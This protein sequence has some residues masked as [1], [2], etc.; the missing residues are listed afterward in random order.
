MK[1]LLLVSLC[2]LMLCVTQGFAQ[3]RVITGT[4]TSKD[5]GLPLPGVSVTVPGTAIGTQTNATGAYSLRVSGS[6][7]VTL[8]FAFIGFASQTISAPE[9]NVLNVALA[10]DAKQLG[11][12][13]INAA[14][15]IQRKTRE[16]GYQNTRVTSDQLTQGKAP[17]VA[18]GLTGKVAGLQIN[19]VSSGVNPTYRLVLRGNRSLTGNN[20]ALLVLDNVITPSSVLGNLNPE[21]IDDITVLN[22]ASAAALYGSDASNGALVVTTKKGK[23]GV[24]EIKASHLSTVEQV[25]FYPK[26]QSEFG[27]G[28]SS[29][30]QVYD[31]IENQQ[32]GP[33]F[34]GTLRQ[35][36]LP[37]QDGSVQT[38]PYTANRD[39]Y[40]FW[41]SGLT[42]QEDFS[43]SS[44]DEKS[45]LFLSGQ[46]LNT[47][48]TTNNDNYKRASVR[49]NGT[50]DFGNKLKA[51]YAVSFVQNTSDLTTATSTVY[52][53]LL[54]TPAQIPLLSYKDYVNNP[55]ANPNG[56]YNGY[57]ANPYFTIDNNRNLNRNNYLTGNV[58]LNYD[59]LDWLGFTGRAGLSSR[60]Q[61]NK[62]HTG[63]FLFT[64][65]ALET[66]TSKSNIAGSESDGSLS[67]V[68]INAEFQTRLRK[69]FGDFL[70][71]FIA[72]GSLRQ[73]SYKSIGVGA[74]SI[75]I[76]GLYNVSNRV[77][78]A[79][80]SEGNYMARQQAVYGDLTVGYKNYLFLHVTGRND[81]VSVLL[82]KNRSFFYPAADVS[83]VASDAFSF[84]K[85]SKVID[86][87]KLRA[88]VSK[89][90]NV[91][92][93]SSTGNPYGAYSLL[94][95]FSPTSGFPYG[96]LG[97][98]SQSSVLV[99]PDLKPEIT[100][101]FEVGVDFTLLGNRIDG[102][103]TYYKSSTT[104]QTVQTTISNSTGF[105]SYL[106]N[107][108][109]VQNSGI[110]SALHFTPIRSSGGLSITIGGNYTY[111]NNN[112]KSI[113]ANLPRLSINGS[114]NSY[115]IEN[116]PFPVLLGTDY[117]RDDQGRVIVDR[118]TGYP[119]VDPQVKVLGNAQPKHRLGVDIEVRFKGLRF[120]TL[121]EYRGSYSQYSESGGSLDFSGSSLRSVYYDR[122][123]FV[124]P[125]SSYL[126]PVSNTYVPNTN[127][128][129]QDGGAGFFTSGSFNRNVTSNYVY[130]GNYWKWREV[131]LSYTLPKSILAG[132]K[133]IKNAIISLQGRNL[134]LW[135]P[136]TNE[137]T[138]PDYSNTDGNAIGITGLGQT[139]PTRY[140]GASLSLTF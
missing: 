66:Y 6:G 20:Q 82:P 21:D 115:A 118:I 101:A 25:S 38:V 7:P 110:E 81:W 8:K 9:R 140:Y 96:S 80:A 106:I 37:F 63:Q 84:I 11:E 41:Q 16:L 113:N 12:V 27:S 88:G 85:E 103:V 32:Y 78:E 90:G 72:A 5:D 108:G 47:K 99:S 70:V 65:Y 46:Y 92:L 14:G 4:V 98:F 50:R 62:A 35:I 123:R 95:T 135:V 55:Y 121:F 67:D 60:S 116:Q 10:G 129:V 86:V 36:G 89:V 124:F 56:Y 58:D 111:L 3:N 91:N 13:V 122:E 28:S 2:F 30:T 61:Y 44:G 136:K 45:T 75:F 127:V 49:L 97:G 104:D 19:A 1:K 33:R 87:L 69:E 43:L 17:T 22:G 40:N 15:G 59:P 94:P 100:K 114:A 138:D 51:I 39:K 120:T 93:Q 79:Q 77:G 34:D 68:Q 71:K 53:Q 64:P 76:P 125:N 31:P 83:F 130:S 18:A 29:N 126:D 57:Y 128:E 109:E 133:V 139:P 42:N 119:Q 23:K 48:G 24:T 107:T 73:N 117:L 137:F 26:L 105:T 52:D 102:S 132:S 54:Q 134:F 74:S 131:S 112:V